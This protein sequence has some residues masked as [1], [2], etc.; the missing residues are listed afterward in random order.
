MIVIHKTYTGTINLHRVDLWMLFLSISSRFFTLSLTHSFGSSLVSLQR[1]RINARRDNSDLLPRLPRSIFGLFNGILIIIFVDQ[2]E[3]PFFH[4][5]L[6]TGYQIIYYYI[7][8]NKYSI[9]YYFWI[10]IRINFSPH[11]SRLVDHSN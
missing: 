11:L 6:M 4:P 8:N 1:I 9:L 10:N 5:T 2:V 7:Y 3:M